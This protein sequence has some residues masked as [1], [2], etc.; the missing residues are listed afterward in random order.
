MENFEIKTMKDY[1]NLHLKCD[2]LLL[3]DIFEK[4]KNNS[5]KNYG[6]CPCYCLSAPALSWDPMLNMTKGELE[7]IPDPD[8]YILFEK[9]MRGGVSYI[10]NRCSKANNKCLKSCNPKP[11]SKHIYLDA[12]NLYG[13]AMCKF[14][15]TSRF[16]RIDPKEFYLNKH[17][18]SSSKGCALKVD[19]EF[20][21]ELWELHNDYPLAP[22]KIKIR[23]EMLSDY[24][25]KITDLYNIPI[26][27]VKKLLHNFS[28][29]EKYL[30]HHGNLKLYLRLWLKLKKIHCVLEFSQCQWLKQYVEFNTQK[31]NRSRKNGD[32]YGKA[33][34]QLMNN[35]ACG[36]AME[37]LRNRIDVKLVSNR[38]KDYLFKMDI[39]SKLYV[40]QNIWQLFDNDSHNT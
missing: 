38:K 23:R 19:L 6:L 22:D 7:F 13:Y 14:L 11:K 9:G 3:A 12:K 39:R 26:G 29:K 33:L 16:K 25:L 20:P 36:K 17:T 18:S 37:N 40:T 4:F 8:M 24:Q 15:P 35:A 5:L 30:I 2:V 32:K 27:N 31:K 1:H 34:F 28:D 21:K 10:S